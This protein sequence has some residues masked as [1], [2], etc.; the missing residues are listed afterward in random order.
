MNDQ[1][2]AGSSRPGDLGNEVVT[3]IRAR[4]F[5]KV[6][7]RDIDRGFVCATLGVTQEVWS[8]PPIDNRGIACWRIHV[9]TRAL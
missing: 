8:D 3:E 7:V 4:E 1:E 5:R 9:R 6:E 2:R